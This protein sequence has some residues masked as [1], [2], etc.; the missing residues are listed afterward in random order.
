MIWFSK[1]KKW[2]EV[3]KNWLALMVM[4]V[5]SY[6][7]GKKA[8]KNYLEMAKLTR[9]QYKKDN[10]E[11]IRQQELKKLRD[12]TAKRK[13]DKVRKALKKERDKKIKEL[14]KDL[15][16]PDEVFQSIGIDKK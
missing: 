2:I 14:E 1:T 16:T 6:L 13:A 15:A 5:L 12:N 11:L 10:E 3:H 8:N 9:D 4:F 7:L